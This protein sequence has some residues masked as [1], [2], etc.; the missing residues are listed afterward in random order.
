M[1]KLF[2]LILFCAT[3]VIFAQETTSKGINVTG[4]GSV[5]VVPDQVIINVR[6]EYS[7]NSA[8]TVKDEVDADINEVIK[9]LKQEGVA[10]KNIQTEYIHL[11]KAYH[12]QLNKYEF[13]AYQSLSILLE[14]IN[15]YE[16]I[17]DGLMSSGINAINSV[18]FESSKEEQLKA[19]ARK[20][21]I[22]NARSKAEE[23]AK[24]LGQSVGKA[25]YV[26]ENNA[27]FSGPI[28]FKSMDAGGESSEGQSIAVGEKTISVSVQVGF[29]LN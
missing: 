13:R 27:S 28:L 15:D 16:K 25:F 26:S 3:S 21:A 4:K 8:N 23:Y 11:G 5:N 12:H 19:E 29:I 22:E 14:D 2:L 24:A 18:S 7:G 17:M 9:F 10:E 6:S 20:K 1:K